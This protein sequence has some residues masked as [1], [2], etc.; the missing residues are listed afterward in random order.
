VRNWCAL[1]ALD[2]RG[3]FEAAA[4]GSKVRGPSDELATQAPLGGIRTR[5]PIDEISPENLPR[6]MA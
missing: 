5:A 4:P 2:D 3:A 6:K 1:W